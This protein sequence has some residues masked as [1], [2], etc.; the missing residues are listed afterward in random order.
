MTEVVEQPPQTPPPA[1]AAPPA[2]TPASFVEASTK[3]AALTADQAWRDRVLSGSDPAAT[4]E[5]HE[6]TSAVAAGGSDAEIAMSGALPD[7]PDSQL[8]MMASTAEMLRDIGLRPEVI[9]Q[10][11]EGHEVSKAEFDATAAY[12][13][14]MM[15]DPVFVKAFLSGEAEAGQKVMLMSIILSSNIKQEVVA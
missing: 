13:S 3:L 6:L 10:T 14:R 4:K 8:R 12:K 7:L 9:L 5:F 1:P 2:A 15:K 11:L